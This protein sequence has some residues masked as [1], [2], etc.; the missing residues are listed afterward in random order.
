MDNRFH[1][2][3]KR[4]LPGFA[5]CVAHRKFLLVRSVTE[6]ISLFAENRQ[7]NMK[8]DRPN[9][10]RATAAIDLRS[11][12]CIQW[13][14]PFRRL[15]GGLSTPTGLSWRFCRRLEQIIPVILRFQRKRQ[16]HAQLSK[17]LRAYAI[18]LTRD[19]DLADDLVQET[20]LKMLERPDIPDQ[21]DAA[22]RYAFKMLRNLHIDTIRKNTVRREYS[23]EQERLFSEQPGSDFDAVEQL[24]VR[25]AFA[26]LS[27]EHREILFLVDVVG[28]KYADA[29]DTLGVANGTIMSRVS[30]ARAEMIK[31]LSESPVQKL[32][33]SR[34][35]PN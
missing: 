19:P 11:V 3:A 6:L 21:P 14:W 26:Q 13:K 23:V 1:D 8:N 33:K 22:Q 32:E 2:H 17:K 9:G 28:F 34:K 25:D 29:A 20:L 30:R 12:R 4:K 35:R 7:G 27:P 18:A 16:F 31:K 5:R 10:A 24:I 15:R